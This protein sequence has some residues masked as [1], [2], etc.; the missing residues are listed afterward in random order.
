MPEF[1]QKRLSQ[2]VIKE[3]LEENPTEVPKGLNAKT[4]YTITVRKK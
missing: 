2:A 1:Y 4:E 3:Y